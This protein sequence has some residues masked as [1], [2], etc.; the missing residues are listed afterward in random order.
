ML[1]SYLEVQELNQ[2]NQP[3]IIYPNLM[4]DDYLIHVGLKVSVDED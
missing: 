3:N 4:F 2:P 1:D